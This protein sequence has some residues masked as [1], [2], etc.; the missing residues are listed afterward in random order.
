MAATFKMSSTRSASML[1][2]VK[3]K[4]T[5]TTAA[6]IPPLAKLD[7]MSYPVPCKPNPLNPLFILLMSERH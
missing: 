7:P 4:Q 2:V 5:G 1:S 6:L 3:P